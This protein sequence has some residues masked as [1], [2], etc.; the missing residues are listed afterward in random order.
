M[1]RFGPPVPYLA[2]AVRPAYGTLPAAVRERIEKELG[3]APTMVELAGGGFTGGF[4]AR[5]RAGSGAEL[6]VKTTGPHL[7]HVLAA[8]RQEARITPALPEGVP[9]PGS[10][11][12]TRSRTGSSW[13]SRRWT[14]VAW[15]SRSARTH[16]I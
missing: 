7:P 3:G 8:Y 15:T 10:T 5:L 13:A 4:A 6:F 1:S 11:S 9:A 12:S 16:S 14:G 2:T